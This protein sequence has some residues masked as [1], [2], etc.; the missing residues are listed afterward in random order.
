MKIHAAAH[1]LHDNTQGLQTVSNSW[2]KVLCHHAGASLGSKMHQS[3]LSAAVICSRA[4]VLERKLSPNAKGL[5]GSNVNLSQ[6]RS[7][8]NLIRVSKAGG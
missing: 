6:I 5:M 4:T 3:T 8:S 2:R 1:R 7:S